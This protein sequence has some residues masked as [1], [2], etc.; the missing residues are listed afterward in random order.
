MTRA[1]F[2]ALN[3]RQQSAGGKLFA[4]PRN[5]AAGSLRQLDPQITA[6]RPLR[7]FAYAWGETSEPIA[8]THHDVLA[9]LGRLGFPVNPEARLCHGLD[10]MLAFYRRPR[11]GA[12]GT[13]L[14]HRRRASS[15]ST[16]WTGRSGWASSAGRRAGRSP[17]SSRRSRR[18]RALK[19]IRIQ[20]GRTGTLT[21]VAEL[22]PVTVGGVVVARATPAQRGRDR[23]ARTSARAT[24]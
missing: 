2:A 11:R 5:A 16:A 20:V 3:E 1:D 17:R 13:A 8:A 12:G 4:N 7:F 15:R 10:E 24:R 21:P 18:E 14:R 23:S 22:T 6:S 9:R 19:Q